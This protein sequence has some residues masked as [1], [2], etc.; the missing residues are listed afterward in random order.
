MLLDIIKQKDREGNLTD[1]FLVMQL[2]ETDLR[3]L[4]KNGQ[5]LNFGNEHV[6]TV[7]Y[8]ILCAANFMQKANILHR[9]IKPANILLNRYL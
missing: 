4:L 5:N 1:I 9:D 7:L 8:N 3:M 6:K 2:E